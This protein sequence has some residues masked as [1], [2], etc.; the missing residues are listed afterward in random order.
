[1]NVNMNKTSKWKRFFALGASLMCAVSFL[2]GCSSTDGP[3]PNTETDLEIQLLLVG[4]G[5]QF[6]DNLVDAYKVVHPEINIY[7]NASPG[8]GLFASTIGAVGNNT[9]DLYFTNSVDYRILLER[10]GAGLLESLNDVMDGTAY[11]TALKGRLDPQ[12]KDELDVNGTFYAL[13]WQSYYHGIVYNHKE[14]TANNWALPRTTDELIALSDTIK[15]AQKT[16][17]I[18]NQSGYWLYAYAGWYAQYQSVAGYFDFWNATSRQGGEVMYPSVDVFAQTGRLRALE[19][20]ADILTVNPNGSY[21]YVN[22]GSN[23]DT[24]TISQTKFLNDVA[25]MMPNGGWMETE[26][27]ANLTPGMDF[28][29][30]KLPIISSITERFAAGSDKSDAKLREIVDYIDGGKTGAAPANVTPADIARVEEARNVVYVMNSMYNF[31]PA[32]A[33]AKQAAKD[34]LQY[35]YSDAGLAILAESL[36]TMPYAAFSDPAN[37]PDTSGWSP[38]AK[39]QLMLSENA[40]MVFTAYKDPVFYRNAISAL[41]RSSPEQTLGASNPADRKTAQQMYED[42]YNYYVSMWDDMTRGIG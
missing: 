29:F 24:H 42:T 14:F 10:E 37:K 9:V 12:I 13:P 26:M 8:Y 6:L 17:F 38:F 2:F 30:M 15:A 5:R 22:P 28:R 41:F 21:K 34:F 4:S 16:P 11:G 3:A 33:N 40:N 7:I 36:K 39:S 20:M 35:M 27:T 31:V 25:M 32:Y 1:M 23:S 19:V 18:H